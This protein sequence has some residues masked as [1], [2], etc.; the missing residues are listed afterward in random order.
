MIVHEIT[1]EPLENQP[2]ESVSHIGGYPNIPKSIDL[3]KCQL[4]D[5]KMTF[6]FQLKFPKKHEWQDKIIAV[7]SCTSCDPKGVI[8][9][10]S[11]NFQKI[12]DFFLDEY[13]KNF[14]VFVIQPTDKLE[15]R[16]DYVPILKYEKLSLERPKGKYYTAKIGGKP[17]WRISDD[18]PRDYMGS[19]FAFLFQISDWEF[20][21]YD[22]APRQAEYPYFTFSTG[23]RED[24]KYALFLGAPL[25]FFGTLELE[26]PKVYVLNQK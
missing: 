8:V 2:L 17:N 18:F 11:P 5:A 9:P 4:C 7:F 24:G 3:P 23:F 14:K 21:K 26:T 22:H 20:D 16:K 10:V 12:P 13:E 15:L 1:R 6:F 19:A 25:Y